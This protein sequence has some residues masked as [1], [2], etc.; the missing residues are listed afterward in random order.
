M[1]YFAQSEQ[2]HRCH[3][4]IFSVDTTRRP[5][6]PEEI[7]HEGNFF[8]QISPIL[9]VPTGEEPEVNASFDVHAEIRFGDRVVST[10]YLG[11]HR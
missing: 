1:M 9:S 8:R 5:A 3:Q 7:V 2:T 6:V 4:H 11:D 10:S